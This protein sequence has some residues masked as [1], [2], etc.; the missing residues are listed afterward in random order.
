MI[1][2]NALLAVLSSRSV[3]VPHDAFD[4]AGG[5]PSVC[6]P[7][8]P[9]DD[10]DA[11]RMADGRRLARRETDRHPSLRHHPGESLTA[12]LAVDVIR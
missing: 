11:M 12:V 9:G 8:R 4:L 1:A 7:R 10:T 3:G 2:A 6:S 5:A